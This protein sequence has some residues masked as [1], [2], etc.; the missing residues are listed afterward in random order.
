MKKNIF[1]VFLFIF[2]LL[3]VSKDVFALDA[4]LTYDKEKG[5]MPFSISVDGTIQGLNLDCESDNDGFTWE[6][7]SDVLQNSKDY[8]TEIN[9]RNEDNGNYFCQMFVDFT[10][11]SGKVFTNERV[12]DQYFDIVEPTQELDGEKI[13][14]TFNIQGYMEGFK[15][16]N[17]TTAV[18]KGICFGQVPKYTEIFYPENDENIIGSSNGDGALI[19]W[20]YT[21]T[22]GVPDCTQESM[23]KLNSY[24]SINSDNSFTIFACFKEWINGNRWTIKGSELGCGKELYITYCVRNIEDIQTCYYANEDGTSGSIDRGHLASAPNPSYC[25]GDDSSNDTENI[26]TRYTRNGSSL[27]CNKELDITYCE[28]TGNDK[29]CYFDGGS[30]SAMELGTTPETNCEDGVDEKEKKCD[31]SS[32][33]RSDIPRNHSFEMCFEKDMD[34]DE[35]EEEIFDLMSCEKGYTGEVYADGGDSKC[36]DYICKHIYTLEC[37]RNVIPL[38]E[39]SPGIADSSGKGTLKIKASSPVGKIKYYYV[40]I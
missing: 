14:V 30:V 40:V 27:G 8:Y 15:C 37:K 21:S 10:D 29:I 6:V 28:G 12:W 33:K 7:G 9:V 24:K 31:N 18:D 17:H 34:E 25:A 26:G 32:L 3:F 39:V 36:N 13:D 5:V 23:K 22:D 16:P 2:M 35:I 4:S 11:N 20:T 19:G 1:K 38:L